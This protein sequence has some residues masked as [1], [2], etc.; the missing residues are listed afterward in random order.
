VKQIRLFLCIVGLFAAS[1]ADKPFLF[2][3]KT[4]LDKYAL[5]ELIAL[6]VA[7]IYNREYKKTFFLAIGYYPYY[8]V[9]CEGGSIKVEIKCETTPVRTGNVA[10]EYWDEGRGRP[11]GVLVTA[12]TRWLHIALT[13]NGL[14]AFEFPIAEIRRLV[15]ER[16]TSMKTSGGILCK[17][18]PLEMFRLYAKRT[19]PFETY[20]M[21]ELL[22]STGISAGDEMR[23]TTS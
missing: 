1:S 14:E 7:R 20:F 12:A 9:V 10:I 15:M 5:Q 3:M 11:S 22:A 18:I 4:K 8:D 16:G 2:R 6:E 17:L 23:E 19:F 21:E 13:S